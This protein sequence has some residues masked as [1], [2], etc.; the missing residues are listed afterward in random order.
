MPSQ[1]CARDVLR[2]LR[3][4]LLLVLFFWVLG[5]IIAAGRPETGP[6]EDVVLALG[7]VGLFALG[8]PVRRIGASTS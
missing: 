4:A 7:I 6:V 1:R 3:L 2:I 8:V 5:L